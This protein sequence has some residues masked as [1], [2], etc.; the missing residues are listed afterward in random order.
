MWLISPAMPRG[1]AGTQVHVK[2]NSSGNSAILI[3]A[4]VQ[5]TSGVDARTS[6]GRDRDADDGVERNGNRE[7]DTRD[8]EAVCLDKPLDSMHEHTAFSSTAIDPFLQ[9]AAPSNERNVSENGWRGSTARDGTSARRELT[10]CV[11]WRVFNARHVSTPH[12]CHA[13]SRRGALHLRPSSPVLSL[14]P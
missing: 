6:G 9:R 14:E 4:L 7:K 8:D 5:G 2:A 13:V 11:R 12:A 3:D 1:V 10:S